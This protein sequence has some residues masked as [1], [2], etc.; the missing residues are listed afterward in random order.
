MGW[1]MRFLVL[2]AGKMG[3]AVVFDLCKFNPDAKI[4]VVD[5][6][7]ARLDKI[8]KDYPSENLSVIRADV[9]DT[10][11]LSY[12]LSG[13]DVAISCVPFR[14]NYD[15]AK[16]SL[17]SGSSFCDLGGNEDIVRKQFLLDEMAREK[18]LAIIPD[19]G[20]APG[21]VSI[22]ASAAYNDLDETHDIHIRVGGLPVEPRPPLNYAQFFSVEGLINEYVEDSTIIKDGKLLRVPSLTD[23]E[24]I[25]FQAP[26][27]P[28]EAFHTS[29]GISTLPSTL[30]SNVRNLDF[31]TIRYQGHCEKIKFLRDLGFMN[32]S[33][34]AAASHHVTPRQLLCELLE[35][36]LPTAEP[37]VVFI[38]VEARGLKK[39]LHTEISWEAIDYMDEANRLSAMMRNS[40][41]PIS[42]IAQMLANDEIKDRGTLY[43]ELSVPGAKFLEEIR[44]RGIMLTRTEKTLVTTG[45]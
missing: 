44:K 5:C 26:F 42:I 6:N 33:P 29:G 34:L 13:A 12:V 37:D 15:L 28:L 45:P 36:R 2:G 22:L 39:D 38:R 32:S 10:E 18:E 11:E 25:S 27:G 31:K 30:G 1:Q 7:A 4:I 3:R 19:C 14:F 20:L 8:T 17:D 21:M 16:A 35:Q 23:V 9:Q 41:F 24:E 40:A 43:Q